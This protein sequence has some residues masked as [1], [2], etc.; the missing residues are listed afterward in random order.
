MRTQLHLAASAIGAL[1]LHPL[2]E[3]FTF[4][5]LVSFLAIFI[6]IFAAR[7]AY[8]LWIYPTFLSPLRHLPGPKDH[9][10]LLGHAIKQFLSGDPNEP[11]LS[12]VRKWPDT[13]MIRYFTFGNSEAVLVTGLDAFRDVLSVK[14]YSFV[15][16][17]L[18]KRL[19]GPI[20]GKG[21]V[22]AEG[23]EHKGHRKLMAG[24]AL[25]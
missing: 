7:A 17:E 3:A 15:K 5:T 21:L 25:R 20:V 6:A 8:R 23:E 12:W 11:Y 1:S 22:F 4:T 24:R 2:S 9:H 10:F 18:Y 14:P 16:P 19:L 13:Q